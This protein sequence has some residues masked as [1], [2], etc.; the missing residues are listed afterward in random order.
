MKRLLVLLCFL[1]SVGYSAI[2]TAGDLFIDINASASAAAGNGAKLSSITNSGTLGGFFVRATAN[3]GAIYTNTFGSVQHALWFNGNA[4]TVMTNSVAVPAGLTGAGAT[5]TIEAWVNNPSYASSEDVF[6]WTYR[7]TTAPS[8]RLV[9]LRAGEAGNAMEHYTDNVSWFNRMPP[10][11]T[12]FHVAV[13]RDGATGLEKLYA[14]G[15]LVGTVT[16][17]TLN[18]LSDGIFI[19]GATQNNAR[20]GFEMFLSGAVGAVRVHAGQLTSAQVVNNYLEERNSYAPAAVWTG[21]ADT[22]LDWDT[23]GNWVNNNVGG[24][25]D[26]VYIGNGGIAK[27]TSD[28][29][30]LAS[31]NIWSGGVNMT[32]DAGTARILVN[33]TL[34]VDVGQGSNVTLNLTEGTLQTTGSGTEPAFRLGYRND[35]FTATANIGGSDDPALLMTQGRTVFIGDTDHALSPGA[36]TAR[37]NLL[38]N[39]S[40]IVSN[41]NL[42]VGNSGADGKITVDGGTL[43]VSSSAPTTTRYLIFVS[44]NNGK[45]ELD[46]NSGEINTPGIG[47]IQVGNNSA[48]GEGILRVNGGKIYTSRVWTGGNT[49]TNKLYL[50]GGE[51]YNNVGQ[52]GTDFIGQF[53]YAYIQAGGAKIVVPSGTTPIA[54]QRFEHDPDLGETA[55]GGLTLSG[56]GM[57]TLSASTNTFTGP[58]T[59]SGGSALHLTHVDA[60]T[61]GGLPAITLDNGAIGWKKAGGFTNLLAKLT[62]GSTGSIVL[63]LENATENID[64][65]GFP[66]VS[67]RFQGTFTYTGAITLDPA[68]TALIFTPE[69]NT[70]VTYSPVIAGAQPLIVNGVGNGMVDLNGDNNAWTGSITVNG[71]RLS[72]SHVN[73]LG[74]GTGA[75]TI[76]S[77][78]YLRINAAVPSSFVARITS[79][80]SGYI[81]L[82]G[83]SAALNIDLTN[84]PGVSLG[85]DEGTLNYTGTI[86]P[87][88]DSIYRLGGGNTAFRGSANQGLVANLVGGTDTVIQQGMVRITSSTC[89]GSMIIT[90]NGVLHLTT[91]AA[92]GVV[93]A[94]PTNNILLDT[95]GAIR[96][97]GSVTMNPNRGIVVGAGGGEMHT[98]GGTTFTIPGNLSGAGRLNFTDG[99]TTVFSGAN[100]SYSGTMDIQQGSTIIGNGATFSWNTNTKVTGTGGTDRRFGVNANANLI[101]TTDMGEP[102]GNA[103]LNRRNIGFRKQ[104]AGTLTVDCAQQYIYNTDLE[105]GSL[106]V[107]ASGAVPSG[108]GRGDV[109]F[110]NNATLDVNG[111]NLALNAVNNAAGS[112]IDSAGTATQ[113][114]LGS[115]NDTWTLAAPITNSLAVIKTGTG[116]MTLAAPAS[117]IDNAVRVDA[118]TISMPALMALDGSLNLNGTATTLSLTKGSYLGTNGLTAYYYYGVSGTA[119]IASY[120]VMQNRL[121]TL[122]PSVITTSLVA[123]NNCDYDTTKLYDGNTYTLLHHG[124]FIAETSGTYAFAL[125]SDDGSTLCIDGNFLVDNNKDQGWTLPPQKT[126]T[127]YLAAGLHEVMMGMYENSGGQGLTL[128]YQAPSQSVLTPVP[129]N[130]LLQDVARV[131]NLIGTG[132]IEAIATT[133][134]TPLELV[135]NAGST[136]SGSVVATQGIYIVKSGTAKQTMAV[137][138]YP[139]STVWEVRSGELEFTTQPNRG[140]VVLSSGATVSL[141]AS[142]A[143]GNA[144]GLMG[145]YYTAC[146]TYANFIDL[147][148]FKNYIAGFTPTYTFSTTYNSKTV[149]NFETNGS[150]FPPPYNTGNLIFQAFW[151]GY[152]NIPEAGTYT[153]YTSSDDGSM[154]F[155]DGQAVVNNWGG[156]G[157]QERSGTIYLTAGLH[158]FAL[159]FYNS[160]GGYGLN[161]SIEGPSLAKQFIPNSM[162]ISLSSPINGAVSGISGA[163]TYA[164]NNVPVQEILNDTANRTFAGALSGA[165]GTYLSK[166]GPATWTLTGDS[167]AFAGTLNV[168]GGVLELAGT[169]SLGGTIIN[170]GQLALDVT[171]DRTFDM[172]AGG[173]GTLVKNE[174]STVTLKLNGATFEQQL[175]VNAGRVLFDNQGNDVIMTKQPIISGSGSWG[176]VGAG[177]VMLG[178]TNTVVTAG[179]VSIDTGSLV[180]RI[181]NPVLDGLISQ[182]D[183]QDVNTLTLDEDKVT[184]WNSLVGGQAYT[185]AGVNAPTYDSTAFG[186]RGGVVFGAPGTET[187]LQ[188]MGS[189]I[190]KTVIMVARF[191]D[192]Q[193]GLGGV[194]GQTYND[195]GIRAVGGMTTYSTPGDG[196]DYVQNGGKTFTNGTEMVTATNLG[197]TP[198]IATFYA[199]NNATWAGAISTTMGCYWY[200]S[201][202]ERF[203]KGEV[204]EM[205]VYNRVIT[206]AERLLIEE[207]LRL[208]WM[209]ADSTIVNYLPEGSSLALDNNGT[210]NLGGTTQT[211]GDVTGSGAITR[212]HSIVTGSI[213]PGGD[214]VVGTLG[215]DGFEQQ[216]ATYYADLDQDSEAPCDTVTISGTGTVDLDGL[217]I[218]VNPL[219]QPTSILKF[220]VMSTAGTFTG[221]PTLTGVTTYWTAVIGDSGQSLYLKYSSGTVLMFR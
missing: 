127:V 176:I 49:W 142:A 7:T 191:T 28:A 133:N 138:S 214:G 154:V 8:R 95:G 51:I 132:K 61:N 186:G 131:S 13:V 171:V 84:L 46:I 100:N 115:D 34:P 110:Y 19:L 4:N 113:I 145:K 148:T 81:I 77:N 174:D 194:W 96:Q 153:F 69:N 36:V 56:G 67:V 86:T 111:N 149:L 42:Y 31:L 74:D 102:L 23:A 58:I 172:S 162:L 179:V 181:S 93:P 195:K 164:L 45:G 128:F 129:N 62:P 165:W 107:A 94:S 103:D 32:N 204:G 192:V 48:T 123:G 177:K 121:A 221:T 88:S 68:A 193:P 163:G 112:I 76:N 5:Y 30:T 213:R 120:A 190:S 124:R 198:H 189:Q 41:N 185:N 147:V 29:G 144:G 92:F 90:N 98:W 161:A 79:G 152:I 159:N 141:T 137:A 187:H 75:I 52:N 203:Y 87:A 66:G 85:T 116:T 215:F 35:G 44:S 134:I 82:R 209:D 78:A 208:K 70:V 72:V 25:G 57:L 158:G 47:E 11:G 156:H 117:K 53:K 140:E 33:S 218:N 219:A 114:T 182:I 217:T 99:G 201:H 160:G 207:Y 106:K 197:T 178:E 101:W 109:F 183:A 97:N 157:I 54:T 173:T 175:T 27:L 63:Y 143:S 125:S 130:L 15:T 155:V 188:S 9:E 166:V 136:F 39:G 151:E 169:A 119:Q 139:T 200:N 1:T 24:T 37:L 216:T 3:E 220:K 211:F 6:S 14:N 126:N 17:T 205:I 91:D 104:G 83:A 89:T 64:L 73:G 21:A 43:L 199:G 16:Y 196:N 26:D 206:D 20:N 60:F 65:T 71:G 210:L 50:N 80:S 10:N 180:L 118:G 167:S 212:G 2:Q 184:R 150:G 122:V 12:W 202:P 59:V 18:I 55:D 38:A 168:F 40:M 135:A 22:E 146:T 105:G 108:A 170:N